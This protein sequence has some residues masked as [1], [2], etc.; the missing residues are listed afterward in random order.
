VIGLA[1]IAGPVACLGLTLLLLARTRRDRLAGLGFA[2]LGACMLAAALAPSNVGEAVGGTFVALA[3]AGGLA[4]A[5]RRVPWL[6]PVLAL[7]CIPVRIG[8]LGHQ[9]LVPL[10]VVVL[11]AAIRL[12]WELAHGDIRARELR[13][14]T[15]PLALYLAWV[16]LSLGWTQDAREGAIEVL[17]FYVPFAVLAIAVAR[18]PWQ[19]IGLWALYAELTIMGLV[20]AVV[21]FYQYETRNVFENPKVIYS[22]AY[23][24]FFRVNSVFWDPSVYGRFLVVAMIPSV[25]LIVRG[26][27]PRI[28]WAAAAALVVT[29]FG[30]LISFSQSSFAALLVAVIGVAFVAWRWRALLAL[31]LAVVVVGGLAVA[32]PT[33]RKSIQH[34]TT[35]GLNSASSGRY[36]LVAN[37]VRIARAHPVRGV[38]VGGFKH[39]YARRV[40]RLHGKKNLKTAASHDT[41]VTVAAETGLVGFAL[42]VWLLVA[43]GSD[44]VRTRRL[45]PFAAG[46]SLAAILVHSLFYNDFFE[47]PTTWLLLGLVAFALPPRDRQEEPQPAVETREAVPA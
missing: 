42:F 21:G 14:I 32:Q 45:V 17:A 19:R 7:A 12:A 16:G 26:R 10:Y 46:L 24:A 18:L 38:G 30:L 36:S 4:A 28:V 23:A 34:H 41:P 2:A 1:R 39:A 31:G 40:Q 5:F 15:W 35:S 3:I 43:C 11:A 25:V 27:S 20:F 13:A 44:V 47:D 37:G 29:W 22:N 9:L 6:L 8:A 33:V